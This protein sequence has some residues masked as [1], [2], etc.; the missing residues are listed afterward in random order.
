LT[1]RRDRPMP[2]AY[3][4][5]QPGLVAIRLDVTPEERDQIRV[6]AATAG[7]PMSEYMRQLVRRELRR[8]A[9][10]VT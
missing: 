8:P 3:T 10:A 7:V 5:R 6:R 4:A 1:D 9:R 2:K